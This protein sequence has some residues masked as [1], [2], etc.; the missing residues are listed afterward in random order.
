MKEKR[1]LLLLSVFYVQKMGTTTLFEIK[2]HGFQWDFLPINVGI[3]TNSLFN[4]CSVVIFSLDM[5]GQT[6]NPLSVS[7]ALSLEAATEHPL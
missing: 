4:Y 6:L 1:L 7:A 3:A 5:E 2:S